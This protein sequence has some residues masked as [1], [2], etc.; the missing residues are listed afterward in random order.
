MDILIMVAIL[1]LAV[2]QAFRL[3]VQVPSLL[4][5]PLMSAMNALSGIALV[6]ALFLLAD[7]PQG[8]YRIFT[9]LA[10]LLATVNVVGGF[11]VTEKMLRMFRRKEAEV[12]PDGEE[13]IPWN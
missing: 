11:G 8:V 10:V 6:G 3:I 1:L 9:G 4:H 12:K 5:T 2:W 13:R 7:E